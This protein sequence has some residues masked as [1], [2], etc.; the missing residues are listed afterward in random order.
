M[1][2]IQKSKTSGTDYSKN[3]ANGVKYKTQDE[4]IIANAKIY[5]KLDWRTVE[6]LIGKM[7]DEGLI[8]MDATKEKISQLLIESKCNIIKDSIERND[9]IKGLFD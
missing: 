8:D 5:A 7:L 1:G 2:L 3:I 4:A 9:K 6:I